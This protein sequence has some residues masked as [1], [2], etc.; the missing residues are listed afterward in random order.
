MLRVEELKARTYE[1]RME[2]VL[3][4]LPIRSSEWTNY[5]ASDPGITI[6]ENLT[7]FSA[8]Q[9]AEIV[10]LSYRAKMALLKMAG[11]LPKRGK[12]ARVLLSADD[13]EEPMVIPAGERFHLGSLC[14]ENLKEG[15]IGQSKI[16][17][18]FTDDGK[19][20]KDYSYIL[21]KD[22]SVPAKLFGETPKKGNSI[23]FIVEGDPSDY[24]EILLYI[25]IM[26][27]S[28]RNITEDR[29]EHIFADIVW[30]C[31]TDDGFEKLKVR[32]FTGAFI[33]SGEI[34]LSMP[35]GKPRIYENTP[36]KGYCIRATL[37]RA[38]Y[39][40]VPKITS[41]SGFLF[42]VWQK[43]TKSFSQSFSRND[44][45]TVKSPIGEDVYYLV[46]GKENKGPSYRR[47]EL[48]T[49]TDL[50]G[51]YCL[52]TQNKDGSITFSFSEENFGYAPIK[53]KESVRVI[54]YNEEIM[55]RYNVGKVIGYDDQEIE[56]PCTNIVHETFFLIARRKEKDGYIYDFVRPE[57][58][59]DGSLYYH[60][61][62]GEGRIII[63]D[64]GDYID[65]DLFMGS[66]S[67]TD[68]SIGNIGAGNVMKM[69]SDTKLPGF[70]NPAG[71]TGGCFR[72]NF[73]EVRERFVQ[74][75]LIP[76]RAVTAE[77]YEYIVKS[78]PGL[79]IRK[80]KA[81]MD[82]SRNMV[83]VTVLPDSDEKFPKLSSIYI[84]K[85]TERLE[86]RRLITSQFE[87]VKPSFV[88]ISVK[89]TAYVKRHYKDC[90]KQIE[91]RIRT[92]IDYINSD[93][94]FGD[95]LKFEDVF[96][97]IDNLDCI[98]YVYNLSLHSE[99]STLAQ[100]KEYDI[101]PRFDCL[102]YPGEIN[103]EIVTSE[104]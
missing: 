19:E 102:C 100:M 68:G 23:Y 29:T 90:L 2:D 77:N 38:E 49:G 51:R 34:R 96:Y 25:S 85:I 7:A 41:V 20:V 67:T 3:L 44:N 50:K 8:L 35:K 30:E 62:E 73:D 72:E 37:G 87:I 58:K 52:Y 15:V 48:V 11:F 91:D 59:A 80:A 98:E 53:T 40:I 46:F 71:G 88:A 104:K 84:K 28:A 14:F 47:Y 99:N 6:L 22:I 55:R 82:E 60:L 54:I 4:E 78:T 10:T 32:D 83:R 26:A 39:D 94:N 61:L 18:I 75:M 64:P 93:H 97:A 74:D 12:C 5:N 69:E 89:C 95:K 21:D 92:K 76:Y 43:D 36:R 101:Y 16:A 42:E 9:G 56:I 31:F 27:N 70:Y 13:L 79:C 81:V 86:E 33:N 65:A 103:V 66:V 57:K 17:G 63:E 24:K 45:I 1:E